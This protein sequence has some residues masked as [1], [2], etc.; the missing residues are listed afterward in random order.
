MIIFILWCGTYVAS[1]FVFFGVVFAVF[2]SVAAAFSF[3]FFD[4]CV[5]FG[6]FS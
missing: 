5:F 6:V 4:G 3:A 1:F 2:A